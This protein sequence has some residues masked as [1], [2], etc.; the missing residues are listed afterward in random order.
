MATQVRGGERE[1]GRV[2]DA[3][4]P[5]DEEERAETGLAA[6]DGRHEGEDGAHGSVGEQDEAR[7]DVAEERSGGE[8]RCKEKDV[9]IGSRRGP[10]GLCGARLTDHESDLHVA[11]VLRRLGRR[12]AAVGLGEVE[13][14]ERRRRDLGTNVEEL[15][16]EAEHGVLALPNGALVDDAG[17][18]ILLLHVGVGNVGEF[19]ED[20]EDGDRGAEA[21]DAKVHKLNRI[22][23]VR[24][25]PREERLAREQWAD[26]GSESIEGLSLSERVQESARAS[27]SLYRPTQRVRR[28]VRTKL[29]RKGARSGGPR[30][31]MKE[32]AFVSSVA[33]PHAMTKAYGGRRWSAA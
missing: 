14:D 25:L 11:E 23:V 5:E 28:K 26:E 29:R 18:L 6:R 16:E 32:L 31:E 33:R 20:E 2:D 22:E 1:D 7:V 13:E 27:R 21:G 12:D 9:S 8:A 24:V 10:A 19:G 17:R 15:G 30:T 4:A 3:L